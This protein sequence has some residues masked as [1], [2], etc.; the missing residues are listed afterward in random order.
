MAAL[1]SGLPGVRAPVRAGEQRGLVP[2]V[3]AMMP[4]EQI[5]A[6]VRL[7]TVPQLLF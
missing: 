4:D 6:L 5:E 2:P 7:N 3:L 1:V